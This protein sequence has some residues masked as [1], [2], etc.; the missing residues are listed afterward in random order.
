MDNDKL[1]TIKLKVH[2]MNKLYG[3]DILPEKE[4]YYRRAEQTVNERIA[5]AKQERVD[6]FAPVDYILTE[7]LQLAEEYIELMARSSVESDDVKR[8]N[9]LSE[10]IDSAIAGH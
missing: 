7:F 8:L 2:S 6:G 10:I 5:A 9:R 4:E 1:M 3:M